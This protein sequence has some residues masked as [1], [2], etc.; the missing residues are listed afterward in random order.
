MTLFIFTVFCGLVSAPSY[1]D[2]QTLQIQAGGLGVEYGMVSVCDIDINKLK[3]YEVRVVKIIRESKPKYISHDFLISVFFSESEGASE[4]MAH[5][6]KSEWNCGS[7]IDSFNDSP[8]W[9]KSY[10][11]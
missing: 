9:A 7:L 10:R 11:L 4:M 1:A 6:P 8:V 3:K 2:D 5:L